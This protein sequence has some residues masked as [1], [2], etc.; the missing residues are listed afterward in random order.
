MQ[1]S[2]QP[3]PPP[4]CPAFQSTCFLR[5]LDLAGSPFL[6]SCFSSLEVCLSASM[7]FLLYGRTRNYLITALLDL[8]TL[9]DCTSWISYR[10]KLDGVG[11]VDNRPST[12]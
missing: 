8:K 6:A 12:N 3:F 10:L 11:P 1:P 7:K 2:L 9:T 5:R 4:N